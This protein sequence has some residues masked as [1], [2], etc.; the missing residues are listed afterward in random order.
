MDFIVDKTAFENDKTVFIKN[1]VVKRKVI[2]LGLR[3]TDDFVKELD[4]R[5]DIMIKQAYDRAKANGRTTLM[6]RDL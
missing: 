1:N 3:S 4:K 2:D 5:V 6:K